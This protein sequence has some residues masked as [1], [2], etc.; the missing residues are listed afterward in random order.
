MVPTSCLGLVAKNTQKK[1]Q[2]L[3][4]TVINTKDKSFYFPLL[5]LRTFPESFRLSCKLNRL[6]CLPKKNNS[7]SIY[8]RISFFFRPTYWITT[9][10]DKVD[11]DL[12]IES[13]IRGQDCLSS[14]LWNIEK[15]KWV[16][17]Q[18]RQFHN[19]KSPSSSCVSLAPVH[20]SFFS[21]TKLTLYWWAA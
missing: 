3:E 11:I 2:T 12:V 4:P 1:R 9:V 21:I 5:L 10:F 13:V 18:L 6:L 15:G 16:V 17:I 20:Y 19:N 8:S 7:I 14:T